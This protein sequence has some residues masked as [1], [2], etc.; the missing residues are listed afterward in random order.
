MSDYTE[1]YN[2]KK[3]YPNDFFDVNDFNNNADIIDKALASKLD[4]NS[5]DNLAKE[6]S[7]QE[8]I[9]KVNTNA[10][11]T[12]LQNLSNKIGNYS[13]ESTS[14]IFSKLNTIQNN[15]SQN[16]KPLFPVY[17]STNFYP[18]AE[19]IEVFNIQ[20]S[21]KLHYFR[22]SICPS[23]YYDTGT[24]ITVKLTIDDEMIFTHT[25]IR[26]ESKIGY[27][28]QQGSSAEGN[29]LALDSFYFSYQNS[30]PRYVLKGTTHSQY[31]HTNQLI[32]KGETNEYI[33]LT[34][35]AKLYSAVSDKSVSF[36]NKLI[37]SITANA[38][39]TNDHTAA[40]EIDIG[41]T[42]N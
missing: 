28:N 15:L 38:E 1:N 27:E 36:K 42:L 37:V 30:A 26:S 33:G 34:A 21:G 3:P 6:T 10:K 24:S 32:W 18:K 40:T 13:D 25:A 11:E 23:N 16:E 17:Q 7:V 14:S 35:P 41:Y 8:I 5:T 29:F 39:I 4:V 19:T 31:I 22:F 12:S 9:T 20:G 2:L